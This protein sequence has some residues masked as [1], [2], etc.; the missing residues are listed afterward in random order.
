M[1]VFIKNLFIY[2]SILICSPAVSA[3]ID[4]EQVMRI[5][6]NSLYFEDYMLSIQYFNQ[7]IQAKPYLAKPYFFR[8]IAKLN[9]D[10]FTGAEADASKA[11]ELNPFITDAY[12]VRGVARQNQGNAAGAVSDY[13]HALGLLPKNRQ[14]MFNMAMAQNSAG[15]KEDAEK[16]FET[17]IEAYPGYENA[18]VGRA[19]MRLESGDTVRA[20][21]DIEKALE[22]N[23]KDVNVYLMRA[24]IAINS[25]SNYRQALEDM[26]QAIK[27]QPKYAGFYINRAFLRYNLEDYFGAM[28]DYDYAID[29]EPLNS[30]ARFNR[31]LLLSE[32]NAND[33]ALEDF[34]AVLDL[35]PKDYR[36]RY[37]RA[38][39]YANKKDYQHAIEDIN[40]VIEAFPDFSGALMMR[41]DFYRESGNQTQAMQDYDKALAMVKKKKSEPKEN[42][43]TPESAQDNKTENSGNAVEEESPDD[44]SRRFASLLTI[45][46]KTE[47]A[48][49]FNNRDIRG[50]VQDRNFTIDIEP[51]ME[52]SY[53]SSPTELRQ[54]TFYIKE[55]E[56]IN[57]TRALRQLIV[58]TNNPPQLTNPEDINEHFASIEY[59]NSYIPT[60]PRRAV[61]LIGRALDFITIHNYSAA[62][63]DLDRAIE[64][65]P[66]FPLS[67]YLRA[68]ARYRELTSRQN[69]DTDKKASD[70][71]VELQLKRKAYTNILEDIETALKLS[72]RMAMAYYNKGNIL[73]ETQDYNS[74]VDAYSQAIMLKSDFGEAYFNR[75]YALLKL[76]NKSKAISDLS[77]AGELGVLP[78]Y[79]LLKRIS[80]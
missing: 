25:H 45:E 27:L 39:I 28:E 23:K 70:P 15:M 67:Y 63:T 58:V 77:K 74:A 8:A 68:Q 47:I 55:V 48:E 44:V 72:P 53:H 17:L 34:S 56:D 46:N 57:A 22:L 20:S 13:Q 32:V 31:A 76:G 37:N 11:I 12:E 1:R 21:E 19:K 43:G 65:T 6:Q 10:D 14:L 30:V 24:D 26:D 2:L 66:D 59:Y 62:I 16:T 7:V 3:Q 64:L 49:E 78:A 35:D 33:R 51:M 42:V 38:I 75:G 60:H 5:G 29:L 52:L 79:S 18:Y 69:D 41:S 50:R 61:D 54:N 40:Y 9:L 71:L 36:A 4:T 73:V 80:R